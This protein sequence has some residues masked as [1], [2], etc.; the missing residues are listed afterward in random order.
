MVARGALSETVPGTW[1]REGDMMSET[2]PKEQP[3]W[4]RGESFQRL[5]LGR[6]GMSCQRQYQTLEQSMHFSRTYSD[7]SII[8]L[9]HPII[10]S[11]SIKD[12]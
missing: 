9:N 8:S 11:M 6:E 4:W 1:G 12:E 7:S 5:Y 10:H 3:V 2:V